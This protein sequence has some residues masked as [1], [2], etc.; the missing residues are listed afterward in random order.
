MN[1]TK[2]R[3]LWFSI[4]GILV[5]F[6]IASVSIFGFNMGLD[7]T[8]GARWQIAFEEETPKTDLE[9]FFGKQE[10]KQDF[11]IQVA[12]DN[13]FL[14]TI[15]DLPDAK[16]QEIAGALKEEVG[17]FEEIAY[18]KVDSTIGASFKTKAMYAILSALAG[19]IIFVAF[20]FRK[21][22][23]AIN[24]WRFGGVA[25]LA[26][27]HDILIVLGIFVA[28]GSFIDV[29]LDLQFI[30]ALLATLGFSVNDTIVIL[31]RVRENIEIQKGQ[32]SFE[33]TVEDSVQQTLLRSINTSVSTLL[34]LLALLFWGADS[35][36]YFVLALV[37]GIVIGTYSSIFLA[38]PMLA[39]WKSWA[40][41]RS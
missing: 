35:I 13:E 36:F 38:A 28:L 41:S 37:I 15:E 34:P 21:I 39:A 5:L 2:L 12:E 11:Q 40:D 1:I 32:K 9:G 26:L 4:S 6:S 25:I 20:V 31:D 17:S 19:I 24:P 33:D 18:R 7:F 27:F 30:T 16:L 14:I 8:G 10:L 29:E 22:P 23:A 3:R